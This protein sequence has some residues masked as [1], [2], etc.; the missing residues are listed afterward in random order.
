M[1]W[2]NPQKVHVL[3]TECQPGP[4]RQREHTQQGCLYFSPVE[5]CHEIATIIQPAPP[6]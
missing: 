1:A 2:K 6:G 3:E 5:I 4:E